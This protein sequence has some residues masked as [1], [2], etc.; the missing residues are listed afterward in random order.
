M[1]GDLYKSPTKMTLRTSGF[2]QLVLDIPSV[3]T[4]MP[5]FSIT[6]FY[7]ISEIFPKK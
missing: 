1:E 4:F 3:G 6:K 5:E 2:L 7:R